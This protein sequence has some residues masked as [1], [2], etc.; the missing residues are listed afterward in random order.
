MKL[1][2]SPDSVYTTEQQHLRG[3]RAL[4]PWP[5]A[6]HPH[7]RPPKLFTELWDTTETS[8]MC[9]T[10]NLWAEP[11]VIWELSILPTEPGTCQ[12]AGTARGS[13]QAPCT[14]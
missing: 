10:E 14:P 11:P 1:F 6:Q 9:P 3:T 13:A 2:Y 7:Q 12:A 4:P 5:L 8:Q